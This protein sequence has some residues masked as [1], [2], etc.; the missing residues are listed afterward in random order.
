M[1]VIF[2]DIDGVMCNR[3]S[4]KDLPKRYHS[5]DSEHPYHQADPECVNALNLIIDAT[6]A[7]I[8]ISSTW[9]FFGESKLKN[10]FEDWGIKGQ[11]IGFTPRLHGP[12]VRGHE[13]ARWL[14]I[15]P[16]EHFVI[17]D[18]DCDMCHLKDRLVRTN[19][20][21]GLT[22]SDAKKAIELLS[23]AGK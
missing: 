22:A 12:F 13:I 14:Q 11:I 20:T 1:K 8:V 7:K 10:I 23:Q 4:F 3:H 6:D 17:L 5:C 15:Y 2:L 21:D 19:F 18:D 9:R 16:V